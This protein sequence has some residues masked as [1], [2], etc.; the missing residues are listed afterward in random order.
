MPFYCVSYIIGVNMAVTQPNTSDVGLKD[1]Y[2]FY[3]RKQVYARTN[4]DIEATTV[5]MFPSKGKEENKTFLKINFT[6]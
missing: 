5:N 3:Q 6:I 2:R 4:N 1:Y